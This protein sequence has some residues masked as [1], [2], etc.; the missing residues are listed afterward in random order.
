V[1]HITRALEQRFGTLTPLGGGYSSKVYAAGDKVLKVYRTRGG[2][3]RH[4]ADCMRHAGLGEWVLDTL[5]VQPEVLPQ[6]NLREPVEVLV[7]RRFPGHPVQPHEIGAALPAL[8]VFLRRLHEIRGAAVD[9]E[10]LH[11]KL[12]RFDEVL[13]TLPIRADLE[14]L[15]GFVR[16]ALR[17][18]SLRVTSSLCHLDLW[19]SN[20]L[21]APP[22]RV[23]AVDWHKSGYDDPAR[24][25][26]LFFTGTLELLPVSEARGFI[27]ELTDAEGVSS[28][29][30]PY[31]ALSTLHDL[32][33][34]HTKQPDGF[35]AAVQSKLPRT[36]EMLS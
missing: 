31:I 17:G 7:M 29:L 10:A 35:T 11:V 5:E 36:L 2:L 34:F 4:E 19:F 18:D 13:S 6:L 30:L 1:P 28:R 21:F 33:W 8:G 26:A 20:V 22:D 23:L 32:Y 3:H 15:F 27:Y 24:D 12:E 25:Y 14:P 9:L 16:E